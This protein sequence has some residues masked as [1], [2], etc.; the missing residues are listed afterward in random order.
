[1]KYII[2]ISLI[3]IYFAYK[4]CECSQLNLQYDCSLNP[5]CFWNGTCNIITCTDIPYPN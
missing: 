1:M 4:A 2:L 3:A 5:G